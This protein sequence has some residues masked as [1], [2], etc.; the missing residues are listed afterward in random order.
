LALNGLRISEA[1]GA[2]IDNLDLNRD[3][4]TLFIYRKGNKTA[5][6]PMS[7]CT[8][9]TLNLYIGERETGP[10]FLNHDCTRSL[11]RHHPATSPPRPENAPTGPKPSISA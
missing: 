4:R 8:A 3:P 2:D 6:I 11:D 7:P 5:T 10:I 9:R 1:L